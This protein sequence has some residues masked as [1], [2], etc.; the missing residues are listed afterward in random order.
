VKKDRFDGLPDAD[1]ENRVERWSGHW[2]GDFNPRCPDCRERD[3]ACD[4]ARQVE[5]EA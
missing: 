3:S 5:T 2:Y 4:D 1:P